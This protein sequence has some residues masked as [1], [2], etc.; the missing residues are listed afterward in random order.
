MILQSKDVRTALEAAKRM[1]DAYQGLA[2]VGDSAIKHP[3]ELCFIIGSLVSRDVVLR[4][5]RVRP[6]SKVKAACFA[7]K[8]GPY[9]IYLAQGMSE[10]ERRFIFCKELFHVALDEEDARSMS[11]YPHIEEV[12]STFPVA[13]S[14]PNKAAAWERIAEI[15]AME[16]LFPYE[17][18]V[19]CLEVTSGAPNVTQIAQQRGLPIYLIEQYLSESRMAYFQYVTSRDAS[20]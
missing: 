1:L 6:K 13:M 19:R 11:L 5:V 3:E 9:E 7:V 20:N 2:L 12:V 10:P 8:E 15:G 14:N 17:E 4:T 18:R 16:F